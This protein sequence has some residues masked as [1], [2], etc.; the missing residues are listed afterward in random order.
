MIVTSHALDRAQE[1]GF[2]YGSIRGFVL[3]G[4]AAGRVSKKVPRWCTRRPRGKG[5]KGQ[6]AHFRYVFDESRDWVA[7]VTI[8]RGRWV[9]MTVY[10]RHDL[11]G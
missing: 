6:R 5:W 7:A 9:V 3:D 2:P 10:H 4:K 1:R 8:D 11:A